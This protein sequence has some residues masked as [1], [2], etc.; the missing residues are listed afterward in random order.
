MTIGKTSA[1]SARASDLQI[2]PGGST[3]SMA[4]ESSLVPRRRRQ[5]GDDE[6]VSG[7]AFS[8]TLYWLKRYVDR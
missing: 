5:S 6:S 7:Q 8:S 1:H 3:E 2:D 4:V